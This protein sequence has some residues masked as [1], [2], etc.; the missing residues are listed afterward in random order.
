MYNLKPYNPFWQNKITSTFLVK[1]NKRPFV[2]SRASLFGTG[3][4]SNHW[5]GDNYSSFESMRMSI[6]GVMTSQMFGFN[7]VGVDICGFS[8]NTTDQL[9]SRWQDLG[10]FY[11]FTRN[12]ND[13][14]SNPQEP[15]IVG[16]LSL[17]SAKKSIVFRY[18]LIR[19][20]YTQL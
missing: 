5:L 20:L 6:P 16:P 7:L 4:Y 9:C 2:L 13:I 14:Q 3:R 10:A 8:G 19:Y 1:D 18:S 11:P 17:A 12:H 15:W